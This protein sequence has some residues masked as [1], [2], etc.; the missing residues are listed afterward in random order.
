MSA[1][2]PI[3]KFLFRDDFKVLNET[4]NMSPGYTVEEFPTANDLSTYLSTEPA[5]LVIASLR[6]KND[7]IQIATFIKLAK[8]VAKDT[9]VKTVVINFSGDRTFDKAIAKLGIQDLIEININTKALKFKLDFWMKSLNAQIKNNPNTNAQKTVKTLDQSKSQDKKAADLQT[10]N[11]VEA[12]DLED[13]IWILKAESDVKKVL[14]KWLIRLLGPSPYIGQWNEV[15]GGVWR[16]DIKESEKELYCPNPGAWFFHGD[17]RPDFV[18][19]ENI[20]MISGDSFDLYFKDGDKIYTRLKL[21]DKVLTAA[22]NSL[23]AKTKE[24]MIIESFDKELVFKREAQKLE[25]LEGKT[26]TDQINGDPLSGKNKPADK[27]GGNLSGKVEAEAAINNDNHSQKTST[28][29]ESKY[30]GGK[31]SADAA[32][33]GDSSGPKA[34]GPRDGEDLSRDRKDNEHQKYYKNH[35]EAEKYEAVPEKERSKATGLEKQA[36]NLSGKSSTDEVPKHYDNSRKEKEEV[37]AKKAEDEYSGK[38]NTDKLKSHLGGKEKSEEKA[39]EASDLDGKSSTDKIDSHY[40]GPKNKQQTPEEKERERKEKEEKIFKE[41]LQTAEKNKAEHA[42]RERKIKEERE[43]TKAQNDKQREEREAA[44]IKK[45]QV[46][47]KEAAATRKTQVEEKEAAAT[48]KAQ[49]EEKTAAETRKNQVEAKNETETKK[50]QVDEKVDSKTKTAV[51]KNWEG[52]EDYE[53]SGQSETERLS[54]HYKSKKQEKTEGKPSEKE[55]ALSSDSAK[56]KTEREAAVAADKNVLPFG[57]KDDKK[58]LTEEEKTLEDITRD[59][60]VVS[61]LTQNGNKS[62]CNLD[63]YF[64]ETIVFSTD[65]Q[66]IE[67]SAKVFLDLLFKFEKD[68]KIKMEGNVLSVEGDGEGNNYVT[69]QVSKESAVALGSFMK[70]YEVRQQNVNEFLKKVKGL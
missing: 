15:K 45:S 42:E 18:W 24:P 61:I 59:A 55:E 47:E 8:K 52:D 40:G 31:N 33:D 69:V 63:D 44:S 25:D 68:T 3:I 43:Q 65:S 27:L 30:W 51:E 4:L 14:S 60:K 38:S 6:D 23:F 37:A 11:W 26:K 56:K 64:D 58:P 39:K 54:S 32:K 36:G 1:G 48:K 67:S 17:Q 21:R 16:F 50:N 7:L 22:K 29:K 20:W 28:A 66:N 10:P 9:M 35:N 70:L 2:I 49:A 53:M 12:L 5:A 34:D 19:K 46:E 62:N 41:R 13:D 57:K